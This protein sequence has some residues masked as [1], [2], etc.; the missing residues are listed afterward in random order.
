MLENPKAD[1]IAMN[2][3]VARAVRIRPQHGNSKASGEGTP[4]LEHRWRPDVGSHTQSTN[5]V[6]C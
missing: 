1:L 4:M 2:I 3:V 5:R 6:S